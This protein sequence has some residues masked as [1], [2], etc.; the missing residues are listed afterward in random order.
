[1]RQTIEN[2]RNKP[3][4][5][6]NRISLSIASIVTFFIF[7]FWISSQNIFLNTGGVYNAQ[8]EENTAS[9]LSSVKSAFVSVF[10]SEDKYEATTSIEVLPGDK[11][12][13]QFKK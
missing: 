11:P 4:H 13:S 10:S 7:M 1:M 5:V 12:K 6:K 8:K 2:L 3:K 9:A